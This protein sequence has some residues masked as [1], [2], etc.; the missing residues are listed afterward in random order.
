MQQQTLYIR[1]AELL[2]ACKSRLG[3]TFEFCQFG[4]N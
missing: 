4:Q 1:D 3:K 2:Q